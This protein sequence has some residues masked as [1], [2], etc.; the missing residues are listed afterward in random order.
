MSGVIE[1]GKVYQLRDFQKIAN[2]GESAM[3]T[4]RRECD[5][6][7]INLVVQVGR[8]S[9]VRGDDFHAYIGLKDK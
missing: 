2:L 8:I 9:F 1:C 3:K 7:G 4:A 5:Q 6:L